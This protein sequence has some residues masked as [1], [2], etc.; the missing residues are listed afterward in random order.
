MQP[1]PL[2][3]SRIAFGVAA[4]CVLFL[5]ETMVAHRSAPS[6]ASPWIWVTLGMVGVG[7]CGGGLWWRA[8]ARRGARRGGS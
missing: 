2:R 4:I 6:P 5:V 1:D 8:Q 3:R 7:A